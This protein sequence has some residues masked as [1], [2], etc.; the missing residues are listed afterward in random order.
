MKRR[1]APGNV[2]RR[3]FLASGAGTGLGLATSRRFI[4]AFGGRI[5]LESDGKTGTTAVI[6]LPAAA[7][8]SAP[9]PAAAVLLRARLVD[10][11]VAA[12]ARFAV[13]GGDGALG[14][15][16]R[17]HL[18]KTEALRAAGHLVHDDAC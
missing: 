6:E 10:D 17:A 16:L 2:S 18:D 12:I 8:S 11:E 1:P 3:H 13:Q 5:W 7:P 14:F 9:T 15:L 4:E